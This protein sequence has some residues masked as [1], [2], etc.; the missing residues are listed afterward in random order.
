MLLDSQIQLCLLVVYCYFP[1][2][3][4]LFGIR[5]DSELYH[6]SHNLDRLFVVV[7]SK[8]QVSCHHRLPEPPLYCLVADRT[9][10]AL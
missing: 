6:V 9:P 3:Q 5:Q 2:I 4:A 8:L 1:Q 7:Q 10:F